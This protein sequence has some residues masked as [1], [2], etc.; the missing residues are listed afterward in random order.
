MKK[1]ISLLLCVVMLMT[2]TNVVWAV[3]IKEEIYNTIYVEFSD[4]IGNRER[5]EVMVKNNHVYVN[6]EE[7]GIR[8]GFYI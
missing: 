1:I 5:I 2:S 3:E 4:N 8:L 6:A 7:L